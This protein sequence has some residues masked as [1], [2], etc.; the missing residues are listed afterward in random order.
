MT[1][2]ARRSLEPRTPSRF[3]RRSN[4]RCR[5]CFLLM[6]RRPPRDLRLSITK[7]HSSSSLLM[8][9]ASHCI[10]RS[11]VIVVARRGENNASGAEQQRGRLRGAFDQPSKICINPQPVQ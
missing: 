3:A 5:L 11:D 7:R 1:L 9:A 10:V 2:A 6:G 4:L 8:M